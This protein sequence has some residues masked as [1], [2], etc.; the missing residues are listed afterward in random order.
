MKYNN[1][2][3]V[4]GAGFLGYHTCL[5]L[6]NRGVKVTALALPSESVD[7]KL[8]SQVE[9]KR[10]DIDH[11]SD[12]SVA[13]LL[14]DHDALIYAAGPDDRIEFDPGVNATE[15]FQKHLVD[16]TER[17][18]QIAK[19]VGVK[20]VIIFGSYFS[21]VNNHEVAGIKQGDLER[22]PYIKARVDQFNKSKA[23][24]DD[25]FAVAVLNIPYV[26]GVAPGKEPIWRNVFVERFGKYPK[27]YYGKGGTTL[28]SARKI[29]VCAVQAL[30]LAEHGSELPVG[31]RNMKFKPMIEQLLREANIDKPVGELPNWL[32]NIAMKKQ[33]K[34]A[35]TA[36]VDSGLDMRYLNKDILSR[37][38]YVDFAATDIQLQ[39]SDYV[40]DTDEAIAET[41]RRIQQN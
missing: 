38:F 2:F 18:L 14:S 27:I 11:L 15:F 20:K 25:S 30:E 17:V 1:I 37:D 40:D 26:F 22:H 33:W 41:G 12:D 5:E 34:Q 29:A 8:S 28:I 19:R 13:D 21:Y 32:M 24:G 36:N 10:A 16:R 3:V 31:S 39:M 7:E 6:I 23:L 4:G 9:I 35:Q